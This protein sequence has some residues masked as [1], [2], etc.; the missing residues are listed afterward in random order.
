[1]RKGWSA[2]IF[3]A[4]IVACAGLAQTGMGHAVLREAGLLQASPGYTA[5]SFTHPQNLPTELGS[6]HAS[7]NV[8]FGIH[9]V[10]GSQREYRWSI[11]LVRSGR[12]HIKA[13]GVVHLPPEGSATVDRTVRTSCVG[14]RLKVVARLAATSESIDFWAA[15]RS[16]P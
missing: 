8:S 6:E 5:L 16:A 10:S 3:A 12:S 15:C 4:L 11:L 9:N 1:V 13:A 2:L 14:G 7:I